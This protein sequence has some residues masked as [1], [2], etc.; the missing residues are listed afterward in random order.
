MRFEKL[1]GPFC[2]T[3][4]RAVVRQMTSRT[5]ALGWWS[6][7]SLVAVYPFTLVWNLIAHRKI[8]RLPAS[9]PTPGRRSL[10]EGEPVHRRPV[11]YVALLPAAWAVW[12]I[13]GLI[14][15]AG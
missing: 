6:P 1:D 5:L 8:S 11:A 4:G 13:T 2:R 15:Y 10:P 7:L 9:M 12:A 3:C 14:M